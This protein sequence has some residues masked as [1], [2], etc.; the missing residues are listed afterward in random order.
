MLPVPLLGIA[1]AGAGRG[2]TPA[3]TEWRH[4]M[5]DGEWLWRRV[6]DMFCCVLLHGVA[7]DSLS[8]KAAPFS[9]PSPV[10]TAPIPAADCL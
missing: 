1:G 8:S 9:S 6:V 4:W 7:R 2:L 5:A 3:G 10:C